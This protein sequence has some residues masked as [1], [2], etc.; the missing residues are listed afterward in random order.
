MFAD[1][2][3]GLAESGEI[4]VVVSEQPSSVDT[5]LH[6]EVD[7]HDDDIGLEKC[8]GIMC[9]QEPIGAPR[10]GEKFFDHRVARG[11]RKR[12]V[13]E[14][15]NPPPRFRRGQI[16]S[17]H[18]IVVAAS[19]NAPQRHYSANESEPLHGHDLPSRVYGQEPV[20][21]STIRPG[22][23]KRVGHTRHRADQIAW[24]AFFNG[25]AGFFD[26]T[27]LRRSCTWYQQGGP[28]YSHS[29]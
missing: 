2:G 22:P 26:V 24:H 5:L 25:K 8:V 15:T 1:R 28:V 11:E 14:R 20:D 27:Q 23:W 13:V 4:D 19:V 21:C 29:G 6:I 10:R 7:V 18:R 17:Q 12:A 9:G 3:D 16:D